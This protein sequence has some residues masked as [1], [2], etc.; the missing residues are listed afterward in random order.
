VV[1]L[2]IPVVLP[3]VF[4]AISMA[5][6]KVEPQLGGLTVIAVDIPILIAV[7]LGMLALFSLPRALVTYRELGILRRL[8]TTPLPWELPPLRTSQDLP[9]PSCYRS[10]RCLPWACGSRR[11]PAAQLLRTQWQAHRFSP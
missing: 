4:S 3:V 7:C 9:W 8:S 1:G 11:W 10:P 2:A 5:Q 6:H